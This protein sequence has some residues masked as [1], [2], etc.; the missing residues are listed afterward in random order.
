MR[1]SAQWKRASGLRIPLT[2]GKHGGYK[3][4]ARKYTQIVQEVAKTQPLPPI[5]DVFDL[6][7]IPGGGD[8]IAY[9]QKEI[10]ES[11]HANASLLTSYL[12]GQLGVVEDQI[13]ALRDFVQARLRSAVFRPP[14]K[15]RE[16]QDV[17]EQL[18]IGRGLS[19]G[20][21]YD[22]EV[23]R[24]KI[25]AKEVIP[26]FVVFGLGLAI[27]AKLVNSS[28]RVKDAIDEINADVAG[29]SQGYRS[30]LFVVYDLGF[31]RDILE[32]TRDLERGGSNTSVIVIKH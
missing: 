10:F 28:A 20:S 21:D 17:I 15:E 5:L 30:L 24:V 23:G 16:V 14:E 29:Y 2:P 25:S 8:T 26:D 11:V 1:C 13:V 7:K 12:E 3:Q 6:G 32:F 4:F 18:L 27:E 31:I 9:Q 22:R 19:K